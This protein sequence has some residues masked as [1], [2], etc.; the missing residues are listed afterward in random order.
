MA[1]DDLYKGRIAYSE[2]CE[3]KN[4]LKSWITPCKNALVCSNHKGTLTKVSYPKKI[5]LGFFSARATNF[6][7]AE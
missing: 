1:Q 2:R 7:N 5:S 3:G 6:A 4:C